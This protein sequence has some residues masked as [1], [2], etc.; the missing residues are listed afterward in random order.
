MRRPSTIKKIYKGSDFDPDIACDIV[1]DNLEDLSLA[2]PKTN[3]WLFLENGATSQQVWAKNPTWLISHTFYRR[4]AACAVWLSQT[5][6][7]PLFLHLLNII[8]QNFLLFIISLL[9]VTVHELTL[10]TFFIFLYK[11]HFTSHVF[12]F[13]FSLFLSV[14][15]LNLPFW[16]LYVVL[17]TKLL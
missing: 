9:K 8:S 12:S 16:R 5:S 3:W 11:Y 14:V 1:R 4:E 7:P 15:L 17:K 6:R 2:S 10:Y 13:I